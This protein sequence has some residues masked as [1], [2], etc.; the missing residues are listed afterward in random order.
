MKKAHVFLVYGLTGFAIIFL[1]LIYQEEA[2]ETII[3]FPID[4]TVVYK[5]VNTG[6]NMQEAKEP[7]RYK[8]EW[9]VSSTLGQR[10]YLRQDIGLLYKNG[11]LIGKLG[12]WK[13]NSD[14]LRQVRELEEKDTAKYEAVSFHHSELHDNQDNISSAQ[15]MSSDFLYGIQS[16][17][18]TMSS[19]RVPKTAEEEE[20]KLLLD[21]TIGKQ[22]EHAL[23]DA[24]KQLKVDSSK[25]TSLLLTELPKYTDRP[26]PGFS[27]SESKILIGRLWEGLYKNYFHGIKKQDGSIISPMNSTIPHLVFSKDKKMLYVLTTTADGEMV[28]LIQQTAGRS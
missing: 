17:Y 16:P 2:R 27:P 26:L 18:S 1:S 28:I 24:L 9:V 25:Q 11:R 5:S 3:F 23:E 19:F 14:R 7:Q 8:I 13:E 20:W 12:D 21:K 10:A 4:E 22:Q 6:L 15:H